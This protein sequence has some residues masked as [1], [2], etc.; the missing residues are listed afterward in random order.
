M[1]R[2]RGC[3]LGQVANGDSPVR[4]DIRGQV[5]SRRLSG[6]LDGLATRQHGIVGRRQL[7]ELGETVGRIDRAV[8]RRWLLPVHR[9]VYAVGHRSLTPEAWWMAGTLAAGP[10]AVLSHRAAADLWGLTGRRR[11]HADV[12]VTR[13]RLSRP[14]L[15]VHECALYPDEVTTERAIPTTTV[16]R[17]I[18]DLAA[19][20]TLPRL[21]QAIGRARTA[22]GASGP[23]V[24][25]LVRRYPHCRGAVALR[26]ALG[27]DSPSVTRSELE[28]RFLE[29]VR[30]R[31]LPS[32]LVNAEIQLSGGP[33]EVDCY[34]PELGLVVE[35]DGYAYHADRSAFET[36]RARDLALIAAGLRTARV[37]WRR[38]RD[39]PDR[40]ERELRAAMRRVA[41]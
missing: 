39:E 33:L 32:P 7:V 18:L 25:D 16:A 35:L 12:C 8:A 21:E 30:Q 11:P 19:L 13:R 1:P 17:T 6:G 24:L 31:G 28:L 41:S 34:W 14:R 15:T 37:T 40:L 5:A 3:H 38:L 29:F 26:D 23:S 22:L 4:T 20:E 2:G 9:G 36:D 27:L 10:G